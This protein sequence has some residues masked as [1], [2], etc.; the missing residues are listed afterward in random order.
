[1]RKNEIFEHDLA[2]KTHR[3]DF[4]QCWTKV[5]DREKYW[6]FE[7]FVSKSAQ[8]NFNLVSTWVNDIRFPILQIFLLLKAFLSFYY[9]VWLTLEAK[10]NSFRLKTCFKDL[11]LAIF[12]QQFLLSFIS[13][14]VFIS[15]VFIIFFI[16]LKILTVWHYST[17]NSWD[18]YHIS[19]LF[20]PHIFFKNKIS[21]TPV[22]VFYHK[23]MVSIKLE[24]VSIFFRALK[25]FFLHCSSYHEHDFKLAGFSGLN[26]FFSFE[27]SS[28]FRP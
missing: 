12:L 13:I 10:V 24:C 9:D 8:L 26:F 22:L 18:W 14:S 6:N 1:M 7:N 23:N 19:D 17:K 16:L 21:N 25:W 28:F 4:K 20:R 11:I 2:L 3:P 27:N 5:I 15:S